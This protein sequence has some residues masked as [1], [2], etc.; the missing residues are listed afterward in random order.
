M[1]IKKIKKQTSSC[2][3][4]IINGAKLVVPKLNSNL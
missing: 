2:Q 1:L 4:N 3:M